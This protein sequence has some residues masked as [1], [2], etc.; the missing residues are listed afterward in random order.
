M[1]LINLGEYF[2]VIFLVLK[3]FLINFCSFKIIICWILYLFRWLN[4]IILLI[5]FINL[6]FKNLSNLVFKLGIWF[7]VLF[8]LMFEVILE[9]MIMIKFL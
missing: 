2:S 5:L 6:G 1:C 7:K 4:L 9:V 8:S 3:I